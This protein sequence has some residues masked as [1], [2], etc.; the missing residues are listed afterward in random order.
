LKEIESSTQSAGARR[1]C[2]RAVQGPAINF[3]E[4]EKK[5][6]SLREAVKG[7][8]KIGADKQSACANDNGHRNEK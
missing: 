5:H 1:D 8:Q 3:H 2:V 7:K 4:S 6:S